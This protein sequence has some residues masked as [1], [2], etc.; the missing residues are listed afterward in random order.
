MVMTE[1]QIVQAVEKDDVDAIKDISKEDSHKIKIIGRN[2]DF[3]EG[4]V[5]KRKE[6]LL[7]IAALCGSIN[8]LKF[9][10]SIDFDPS[11][12]SNQAVLF[13]GEN[14]R[15]EIAGM[16]LEDKRVKLEEIFR[17]AVYGRYPQKFI[18]LLVNHPRLDPNMVL[19]SAAGA[20]KLE[21]VKLLLNHPRID[22]STWGNGALSSAI[23]FEHLEIVLELIKDSRLDLS[24]EKGDID[25][26]LY[27]I[28][29]QS[30]ENQ[31]LIVKTL[32]N[33]DREQLAPYIKKLNKIKQYKPIL[34]EQIFISVNYNPSVVNANLRLNF[35]NIGSFYTNE[36]KVKYLFSQI[37]KMYDIVQKGKEIVKAFETK[38]TTQLNELFSY[39][40][41]QVWYKTVKA[42]SNTS[43]CTHT[44]KEIL[45]KLEA[46][47][48]KKTNELALTS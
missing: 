35:G 10:L 1:E 36:D 7:S 8:C 44:E 30:E 3:L 4:P 17:S 20:G 41:S 40:I 45:N 24:I 15:M 38:D 46:A 43:Y 31:P 29:H 16:L 37:D 2:K 28:I 32:K 23:R 11:E 12:N 9:L 14:G 26:I 34:V 13:A 22:L 33:N 27:S 19:D 21:A 6:N 39:N 5:W 25:T 18:T 47:K 48:E 42:L